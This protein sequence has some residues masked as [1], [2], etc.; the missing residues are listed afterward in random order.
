MDCNVIKRVYP[1]FLARWLVDYNSPHA[2]MAFLYG[3][4]GGHPSVGGYAN[5]QFTAAVQ[6]ADGLPPSRALPAY[7]AANR[8]LIADA[9]YGVVAY[10]VRGLL[11]KPYL[12]GAGTSALFDYPCSEV[13]SSSTDRDAKLV[14]TD[15]RRVS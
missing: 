6:M 14:E 10:G 9:A 15:V 13:K 8:V 3:N 1:L 11:L 12:R 2:S 5:P 4:I 7:L